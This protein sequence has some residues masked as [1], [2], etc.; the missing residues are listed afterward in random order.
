MTVQAETAQS[1]EIISGKN[2]N[3]PVTLIFFFC[4]NIKHSP[5][6]G[7]KCIGKFENSDTNII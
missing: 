2:Y 6:V 5:M 1:R 3:C 7:S 4:Q